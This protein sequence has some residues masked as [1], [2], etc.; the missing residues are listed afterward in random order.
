MACAKRDCRSVTRLLWRYAAPRRATRC[1]G[2]RADGDGV[3]YRSGTRDPTRLF[4]TELINLKGI[5]TAIGTVT[6]ETARQRSS[7]Y[8]SSGCSTGANE[9]TA[10]RDIQDCVDDATPKVEMGSPHGE[11]AVGV[12]DTNDKNC[13]GKERKG[14]K[15]ASKGSFNPSGNAGERRDALFPRAGSP[16]IASVPALQVRHDY[17]VHDAEDYACGEQGESDGS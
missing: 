17:D 16:P 9:L 14:L 13:D 3:A 7:G 10:S 11:P 2:G 15:I 5:C 1:A 4:V 6:S 8:R 12:R